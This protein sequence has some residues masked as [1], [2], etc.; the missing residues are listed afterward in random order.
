MTDD[1]KDNVRPL[2]AALAAADADASRALVAADVVDHNPDPDQGP[3]I[4]G[5]IEAFRAT[6]AGFPDLTVEVLRVIAEGDIVASHAVFRGTHTGEYMGV[7]PTGKAIEVE[8]VDMTRWEGGK[9][10]ERWGVF[11]V[12]T[13][14]GQ[15][16]L[17][18]D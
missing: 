6:Q 18:P 11:D 13:M 3:G 2:Y 12:A 17:L 16:G 7:P 1:L 14:M 5:V 9:L 10:A 15:L 4:D 8:V